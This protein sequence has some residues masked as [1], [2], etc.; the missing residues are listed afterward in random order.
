[1]NNINYHGMKNKILTILEISPPDAADSYVNSAWE[2]QDD[3][4]SGNVLNS[5][6]D[7]ALEDCD[8]MGPFYELKVHHLP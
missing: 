4:Y 3:P 5:C 8:Q 7:G 1:M 6:N 2:L